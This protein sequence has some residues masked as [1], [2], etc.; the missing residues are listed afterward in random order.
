MRFEYFEFIDQVRFGSTFY[1]VSRLSNPT[2]TFEA[3]FVFSNFELLDPTLYKTNN[4]YLLVKHLSNRNYEGTSNYKQ[5][6]D[7]TGLCV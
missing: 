3:Q 4:I 5:K 2:R 6:T 1:N 7:K